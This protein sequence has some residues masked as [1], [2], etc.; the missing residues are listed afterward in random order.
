M[1]GQ[2][3]TPPDVAQLLVALLELSPPFSGTLLDPAC[4]EGALLKASLPLLSS[5][6]RLRGIELDPLLLDRAHQ[7]LAMDTPH[8]TLV[9]G[10]ALEQAASLESSCDIVL[11]NP[12][13]LAWHRIPQTLR[14]RLEAGHFLGCPL[15]ARP[16]HGDQQPD[17][18]LFFLVLGVRALKPG[19]R[20][21]FLMAPEWW[22][23]PRAAGLRGWLLEH[24]SLRHL[25][26]FGPQTRVFEGEE[27]TQVS[28]GAMML[29]GERRVP[30][31]GHSFQLWR[32]EHFDG[33]RAQTLQALSRQQVRAGISVQT[34]E[35]ATLSSRPWKFVASPS[36]STP[37][38]HPNSGPAV[39][40]VPL[41][42][43]PGIHIMGGH[44]PKVQWLDWLELDLTALLQLP[45]RERRW[46]QPA[47]RESGEI[48]GL[49]L[50]APSRWWVFLPREWDEAQLMQE[51]PTLYEL[52]RAKVT[53]HEGGQLPEKWWLF[54]N[55][56]NLRWHQ[57]PGPS[58]LLPRTATTLRAVWDEQGHHFKGTNTAIRFAP[59][60]ALV[61][62]ALWG[63]LNA[64]PMQQRA[65][66]HCRS[67][68]GRGILLE[69]GE[70]RKLEIPSPLEPSLATHWQAVAL[71]AREVLMG[72]GTLEQVD[73]QV[74][75]LLLA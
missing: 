61:P 4:G 57:T 19:G 68:H 50:S 51:A 44:Q 7:T 28:T 52:I 12:P 26:S 48:C 23:A 3:F 30:P 34:L 33:G 10:D 53:R 70:V 6:A 66:L 24:L 18:S 11:A 46:A 9:A 21:A 25:V 72:T 5:D 37:S 27:T 32:V 1:L 2:V 59:D 64:R 39:A 17:L 55:P 67:Y 60:T 56:R 16:R 63:L 47:L 54:P 22:T 20:L 31:V 38:R 71:A 69:P 45:P 75:R 36:P 49:R 13:Y 14:H 58:L 73:V 62:H 42:A 74:E 40:W 15:P 29:V 41:E 65:A 8:L 35:Q 43:V